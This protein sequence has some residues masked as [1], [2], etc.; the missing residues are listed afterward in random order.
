MRRPL[1]PLTALLLLAAAPLLPAQ[2]TIPITTGR[3]AQWRCQLQGGYFAVAVQEMVSVSMHEYI[4]DGSARV[5]EA[6]IDTKGNALVRFYHIEPLTPQSP[7]AVGQTVIN[8]VED[9]RKE[10]AQRTGQEEV[11]KKVVKTYPVSTHAHTI[12]YRIESKETLRKLVES[13]D[14]ALKHARDTTFDAR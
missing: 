2:E 4:V 6:N 13:A 1:P 12:D 14:L 11:W 10:L 9:L 3:V 5:T 7:L 8:K